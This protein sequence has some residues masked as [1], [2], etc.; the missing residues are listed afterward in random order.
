M[1]SLID[2]KQTKVY[3]EALEEGI[4]E[5]EI[6]TKLGSIPRMVKLGLSVEIIAAS[7][8]LPL[9]TVQQEVNKQQ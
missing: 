9:E 2:L 5:G 4:K 1:F 7:L 6:L 3:Q 8:D